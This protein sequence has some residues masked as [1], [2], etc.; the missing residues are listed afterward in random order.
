MADRIWES[1]TN[2]EQWREYLQSLLKRSDKALLRAITLIYERQTEEEKQTGQSVVENKIGF[3]KIDAEA[4]GSIAKRIIAGDT[5][6]DGELAK[7]RN[8]MPKYWKQLMWI[9]KQQMEERQLKEE[10]EALRQLAEEK[11]QKEEQFRESLEILRK[12]SEE[13]IAC[14]YGICDECPLVVGYQM[15]L[16]IN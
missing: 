5:L 8:K 7:A 9:S 13:G 12:C 4:L 1:F 6:T 16:N 2:Q 14:D 11:K 10:E 3:S 15:K